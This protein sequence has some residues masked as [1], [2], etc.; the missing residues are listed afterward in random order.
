MT[1]IQKLELDG[2]AELLVSVL[3]V[4]LETE[5]CAWLEDDGNLVVRH[6]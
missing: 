2:P 6:V 4:D 3:P 1:S 5:F